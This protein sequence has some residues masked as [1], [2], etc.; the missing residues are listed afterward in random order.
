MQVGIRHILG[1]RKKL[2]RWRI[3]RIRGNK[4]EQLGV[5][6]ALDIESAIKVAIKEF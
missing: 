6:T 3:S 2:S 5:V 1:M 4:A